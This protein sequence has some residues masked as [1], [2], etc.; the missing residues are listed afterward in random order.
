MNKY[1]LQLRKELSEFERNRNAEES[2]SVLELLWLCY[3][4]SKPVDDGTIQKA[5]QALEP[6]CSELS[7]DA[8]DALFAAIDDLCTAYQRSAFFEGISIGAELAETL[9]N[10]GIYRTQGSP[11]GQG[12]S[13]SNK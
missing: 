11:R 8:S 2:I 9:H 7:F 5:E 12:Q 6:L 1:I 4:H 10:I 3:Y 13:P